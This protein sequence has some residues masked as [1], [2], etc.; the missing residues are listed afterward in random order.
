MEIELT[1]S[2]FNL[3]NSVIYYPVASFGMNKV[4]SAT[5]LKEAR[6]KEL[7]EIVE[8]AE[9]NGD[10][11]VVTLKLNPADV[12]DLANIYSISCDIVDEIEMPLITGYSWEESQDLVKKLYTHAEDT[13]K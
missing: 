5:G 2:E 13:A 6:V 9:H 11:E 3:L 10:A 7:V 4:L 12:K 1:K 8:K